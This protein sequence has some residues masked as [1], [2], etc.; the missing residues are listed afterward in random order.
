MDK[1]IWP[2]LCRVWQ[3]MDRCR[4][5]LG[6][7][8]SCLPNVRRLRSALFAEIGKTWAKSHGPCIR[9]AWILRLAGMFEQVLDN[10]AIRAR[11]PMRRGP[12]WRGL[13]GHLFGPSAARP[14]RI[15]SV[16]VASFRDWATLGRLAKLQKYT[17]SLLPLRG[18]PASRRHEGRGQDAR[19]RPSVS[20]HKRGR[21]NGKQKK[22]RRPT[23]SVPHT[24]T[25]E[26]TL[27]SGAEAQ[28][29][30]R[31]ARRWRGGRNQ[32]H[33][34]STWR[35]PG[36]ALAKAK[37]TMPSATRDRANAL[38]H[39]GLAVESGLE[40][41]AVRLH[42]RAGVLNDRRVLHESQ[43]GDCMDAVWHELVSNQCRINVD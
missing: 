13:F 33:R 14:A 15:C 29:E 42:V 9:M 28:R 39:E 18:I 7:F 24:Q 27:A 34:L 5:I 10:S 11:R 21:A 22:D 6:N 31:K 16:F 25:T 38:P 30:R 35:C 40:F 4:P 26:A 8:G 23:S 43:A 1:G 37:P 36:R 2:K 32:P 20:R 12:I 17:K 41:H 19:R 3:K